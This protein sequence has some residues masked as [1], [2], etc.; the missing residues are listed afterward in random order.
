MRRWT[1]KC[2]TSV[3]AC[4]AVVVVHGQGRTRDGVVA[5]RAATPAPTQAGGPTRV[6]ISPQLMHLRFPKAVTAPAQLT[7][8]QDIRAH[9]ESPLLGTVTGS[10]QK[11]VIVPSD[12]DVNLSIRLT[13]ADAQNTHARMQVRIVSLNI[14]PAFGRQ[15][16]NSSEV[17]HDFAGWPKTGDVLIPAGA[18][19]S[20]PYFGGAQ[21]VGQEA[22]TAKDP[23]A[24]RADDSYP[25]RP[26][27][28][29][30]EVR[31]ALVDT[32]IDVNNAGSNKLFRAQLT[33][34]MACQQSGTAMP[35]GAI[36]L[37]KGNDVYLRS[38]EPDPSAPLGHIA[39]WTV[40]FVVVDGKRVPVRGVD[41]RQSFTPGSMAIS[42]D[43]KGKIPM[44]LWPVGQARLYHIA[45]QQEVMKD[46]STLWTYPTTTEVAPATSAAS[47]PAQT[48]STERPGTKTSPE[49]PAAPAGAAPGLPPDV[50]QRIDD[51]KRRAEELRACQ[52]Q[53]AKEHSGNPLALARALG[54][55]RQAAQ[56]DRPRQRE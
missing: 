20:L 34:D 53:A 37:T 9:L 24:D 8:E 3:I 35:A 33:E 50:Q 48:T 51:Q 46:G 29:G 4:A 21:T 23:N 25:S 41:I 14:D 45:E 28:Q 12:I 1:S 16:F 2:V 13:Q 31:I 49:N 26:I 36:K 39:V 54:A 47:T 17:S 44:V 32:P 56:G 52:Q 43:G 10:T 15:R 30:C 5:P 19:L 18:T 11:A 42:P 40:A 27:L 22:L 7:E 38:Y 55:C 6:Q